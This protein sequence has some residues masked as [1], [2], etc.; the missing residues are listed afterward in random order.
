MTAPGGYRVPPNVMFSE[1][2]LATPAVDLMSPEGTYL[3]AFTEADHVADFNPERA[4]GSYPGFVQAVRDHSYDWSGTGLPAKGFHT[5]WVRE[6]KVAPDGSAVAVVCYAGGVTING[7]FPE[8]YNFFKQVITFQ[9]AGVSPPA[10]QKGPARAPLSSVFGGWY[11][12]NF[13]TSYPP[14][15]PD[16]ATNPPP[17]DKSPVSTPGWPETPGV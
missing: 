3:R 15:D 16:C 10:N 4:K 12:S 7:S 11:T 2:W 14:M 6:L 1:H 5:N 17:V 8:N 9:R 13:D